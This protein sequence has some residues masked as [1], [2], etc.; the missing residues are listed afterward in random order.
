MVESFI[1]EMSVL[2][3]KNGTKKM[4]L[5]IQYDV[6]FCFAKVCELGIEL[7]WTC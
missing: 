2:N 3:G 7:R 6:N 4:E 1:N 5:C